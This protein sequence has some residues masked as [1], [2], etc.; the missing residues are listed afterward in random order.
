M[1]E[2]SPSAPADENDIRQLAYQLWEEAGRPE[3]DPDRYW[4]GAERLLAAGHAA[5]PVEPDDPHPSD[6]DRENVY[7]PA[8]GGDRRVQ[9]R[10]K[11]LEANPKNRASPA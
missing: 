3:G 10:S 5:V 1:N 8:P 4:H 9:A 11:D 7:N 2:Q 6:E